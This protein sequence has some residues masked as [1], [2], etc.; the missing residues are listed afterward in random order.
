MCFNCYYYSRL[1]LE[2]SIFT[3]HS[4][5]TEIP[6]FSLNMSY[7]MFTSVYVLFPHT[8]CFSLFFNQSNLHLAFKPQQNFNSEAF[9]AS[10]MI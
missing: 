2:P 8:K 10:H 7:F 9:L 5:Q 6:G 3:I 1:S 4:N